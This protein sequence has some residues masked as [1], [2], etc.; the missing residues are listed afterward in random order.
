MVGQVFQF[1]LCISTF[2][3]R[4]R[5]REREI[6]MHTMFEIIFSKTSFEFPRALFDAEVLL[7]W[8]LADA[9]CWDMKQLLHSDVR[10]F[11]MYR[12]TFSLEKYI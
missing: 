4:K 2:G 7:A 6:Y 8:L 1:A 11:I 10:K 12:H 5:E 9:S 3:E